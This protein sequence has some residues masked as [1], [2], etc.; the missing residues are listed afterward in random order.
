MGNGI[1]KPLNQ[2]SYMQSENANTAVKSVIVIGGGTAG[3]MSAIAMA[4]VLPQEDLSITLI[5]SSA[6]G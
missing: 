1:I 6:I 5:E 3:W 4:S 2:V